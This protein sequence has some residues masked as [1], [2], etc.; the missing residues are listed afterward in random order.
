M[1]LSLIMGRRATSAQVPYEKGGRSVRIREGDVMTETGVTVIGG[2]EPRS[3]G[4]LSLEA[5][6]GQDTDCALEPG[7]EMQSGL[8]ISRTV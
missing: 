3:A 7:G 4:S 2:Q 8:L 5:G 1:G 6:R